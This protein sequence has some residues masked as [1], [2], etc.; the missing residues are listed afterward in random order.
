MEFTSNPK[1]KCCRGI[2]G[3]CG[4]AGEGCAVMGFGINAKCV[5]RVHC[6]FK[7]AYQ[8]DIWQLAGTG[9]TKKETFMS[10]LQKNEELK[11]ILLA[12]T[13]WLTEAVNEEEQRQR[14]A[15]LFDGT[16]WVINCL[17]VAIL[18]GMSC[19]M[20][21]VHGAGTRVCWQRRYDYADNGNED[22][23]ARWWPWKLNQASAVSKA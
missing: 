9:G 10:R 18:N 8:T 12:E 15:T 5:G 13:P 2:A 19:K 6:E 7:S 20:G 22:P 17:S 14:I 23:P 3:G 11:N 21:M 1:G 4:S 16:R